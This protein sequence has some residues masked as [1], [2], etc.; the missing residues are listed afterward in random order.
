MQQEKTKRADDGWIY[1]TAYHK[2]I[3]WDTGH[4]EDQENVEDY[5]TKCYTA[6]D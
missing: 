3:G 5:D 4:K 1:K 6:L 2:T